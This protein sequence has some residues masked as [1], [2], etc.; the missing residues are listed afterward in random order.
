[1]PVFG[2]ESLKQLKTCHPELQVLFHEVIKHF[3]CKIL[4][5]FRNEQAQEEAFKKGNSKL[6]WPHGKHNRSPSIAVDVTP[7]PVQW[8]NFSRFYWFAGYVLGTAQQLK[9]RG[10]MKHDVRYGG[11]WDSDK[12]IADNKFAD[13]VHFELVIP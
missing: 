10:I 6:H 11:D 8:N 12:E 2:S 1:M 3:D 4:E 9:E 5:G 7:V 13:L